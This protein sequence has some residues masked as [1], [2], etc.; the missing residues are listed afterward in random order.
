M[1]KI[2][3]IEATSVKKKKKDYEIYIVKG[4]FLNIDAFL[5]N[6]GNVPFSNAISAPSVLFF[7]YYTCTLALTHF[8]N[9]KRRCKNAKKKR[10]AKG[11]ENNGRNNILSMLRIPSPRFHYEAEDKTYDLLL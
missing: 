6:S 11:K 1:Y 8:F 7:R 5:G 9:K 3:N 10:K 4:L 2:L